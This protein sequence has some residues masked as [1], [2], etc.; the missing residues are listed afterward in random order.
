LKKRIFIFCIGSL[1]FILQA[2]YSSCTN[3]D[4]EITAP[5]SYT[6][7]SSVTGWSLSSRTGT[8]CTA[9]PLWTPG[10]QEFSIVSTPLSGIPGIGTLGQSPFGGTVVARLNTTTANSSVTRLTRNIQ[11]S[12]SNSLFQFAYAG[13]YENGNHFCCEQPYFKFLIK[14]CSGAN[15][16]CNIGFSLNP[17]GP[18]CSSSVSTYTVFN[19]LSWTNWQ[20]KTVDLTPYLGACVTL[21]VIQSDCING[22]HY[23]TTFFDAQCSNSYNY[24][25]CTL[26]YL[27]PLPVNMCSGSPSAQLSAPLGYS[28]YQWIAPGGVPIFQP[29]SRNI[30]V[31]GIAGSVYTVNLASASG[32][33]TSLTYTIASSQV[34]VAA[35]GM[36]P[37][38]SLNPNGSATVLAT[39]SG[40]GYNYTWINSTGSV[41]ATTSVLSNVPV[42]LY[43][44]NISVPGSASCGTAAATATV[45]LKPLTVTNTTVQ[46]CGGQVLLPAPPGTNY[47]WYGPN[48]ALLTGTSATLPTYTINAPFH[49]INYYVRYTSAAGC[50]DS[51]KFTLFAITPGSI[52]VPPTGINL[53]C[54]GATNGTASI[55]MTPGNGSPAGMNSFSVTSVGSTPSYS[56][57]LSNTAANS[58]T[59]GGLSA[60]IYSI[61]TSDGWCNYTTTFSVNPVDNFTCSLTPGAATVCSGNSI[62]ANVVFTSQ[63]SGSQYTYSWSPTL[64]LTGGSG[65]QNKVISPAL[66][67]GMSLNIIYSVVVT[68]SASNCQLTKTI[69]VTAVNPAS[70]LISPVNPFCKGDGAFSITVSPPGGIFYNAGAA[71]QPIN[72]SSGILT[73]SLSTTGT[74]TFTYAVS[75]FSCI[76]QATQTY[77]V[78]PSPTLHVTGN[79]SVCA[80]EQVLLNATGAN[81]YSWSNNATSPIISVFPTSTTNYTVTGYSANY[82]CSNAKIVTVDVSECLG[83]NIEYGINS[84]RVYPN[85]AHDHFIY[86]SDNFPEKIHITDVT[87]KTMLEMN[88]T[89]PIQEVNIQSLS[90]GI[91]FIHSRA[92]PLG[93]LLI[94]S[95]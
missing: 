48:L 88:I 38:C 68:S 4:F 23:G 78:L 83:I 89:A 29:N 72:P 21:E 74:K 36:S 22:D 80:G 3:S 13:V 62:T 17:V 84:P 57:Y 58:F 10:S 6:G 24:I 7:A 12:S 55:N 71:T 8:S 11:V 49:L 45:G 39:G 18:L 70:P 43:T 27:N 82:F 51:I 90:S 69:S 60:G 56:N 26:P 94:K 42:G 46:Y 33:T 30:T 44:V 91:Y 61:V 59:I 52:S 87:G 81:T 79:F 76:A 92:N 32:C 54:G 20:I 75:I 5:G 77:V 50:Q 64:W 25:P 67:A 1:P 40:Q 14:D 16:L 37:S 35:M 15:L 53:A 66:P 85:P 31:N 73:P 93:I 47:K 86:F 65:G 2:Q 41:V 34:S 28:S 9:P 63:P 95:D 19:G